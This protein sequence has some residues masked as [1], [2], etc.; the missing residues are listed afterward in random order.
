MEEDI[1][2]ESIID[3]Y[4][5]DSRVGQIIEKLKEPGLKHLNIEG[6]IGSAKSFVLSSVY[7]N[8]YCP[9]ICIFSDK[10]AAAY[11]F[12]DLERIIKSKRANI[13]GEI[14]FFPTSYKNNLSAGLQ[15]NAN[16]LAR[17]KVVEAL[18]A[19]KEQ[20]LIVTY[21]AAL[22]EK[23][24]TKQFL[25]KNTLF[26]EQGNQVSFDFILN[27][28][29]E[30]NFERVDFVVE[31]G[32]FTI[33]GG[34]FDVFSYSDDYPYRIELSG[35]TVASLRTFNPVNQL[36]VKKLNKISIIPNIDDRE[37]REQRK[38]FFDLIGEKTLLWAD[39][40]SQIVDMI[41][42]EIQ[43]ALPDSTD[44]INKEEFLRFVINHKTIELSSVPFF[45][46]NNTG[47][48]FPTGETS[49]DS[50]E[51]ST[52]RLNSNYIFNTIPQPHFSKNFDLFIQDLFE[53]T[54]NDYLNI[55]LSD[56]P[57]QTE[58][59]NTILS[60][61][62]ESRYK[63]KNLSFYNLNIA[64]YQGFIDSDLKLACYTDHQIFDR[65]HRYSLRENFEG[66]EAL[67]IKELTGL[68][69]GDY[70]T[71]I[72]YGIGV[73]DGLEKIEIN[74]KEQEAI[75][76]LY[77]DGDILYISIY[78]LHTISKYVG[79]EGSAPALHRLG[80]N[81]WANLK[82]KTKKKVK[83]IAKDLI[84]LYAMRKATVAFA[85]SPDTYL[86][87]ELEASFIYEDTPDQVKATVDVKKD[88]EAD[89]PMDR[90][91]CGDVG[92]GKTEIAVRAAFKAVAD[93]KQV[94]MLVPTTILALQHYYTF[95]DRLKD[96]PCRVEYVN[97][98]KSSKEIKKI[99]KDLE[100]GKV[101]IIIGTH[102]LLSKDIKFKDLGLLIIDEEQKFGVAAKEKI[103][104][105]KVNVD[106]LILTATPIPRTLQFSLMGAR[107]MSVISTPPPNRYPVNT[108]VHPFNEVIIKEAIELEISRGGQVFFVH[109]RI[110]NIIKIE[111]L[112]HRLLPGA[113][114]AVAHGR[115]TG[116]KLEKI[117]LDFIQGDYDVLLSTAI[118]ESGLDIA[119]VNTIIINDAH[120]FGLSDLHQLRGRV[121]RTNKKA[122]CYLLSPPFSLLSNDAKKRLNA[123]EEFSDLSSGFNIALRDLDIRG[124]GNILGGEQSGFIMEIGFETYQKILDEA[125]AEL[126][127][128]DLKDLFKDEPV[129]EI[130]RDCQVDTDLN[131][132]IP[133]NYVNNNA[134]RFTLYK[135]LNSLK[136]EEELQ[137]FILRLTDRFGALPPETFELT[138]I[139]RLRWRAKELGFEKIMLKNK[140]L[141]GYF[142]SNQ[143]SPFYKSDLFISILNYVKNNHHNC[144]LKEI[145][146]K[147]SLSFDKIENISQAINKLKEIQNK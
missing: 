80:S 42:K 141:T 31:P 77:K 35:D 139:I 14:L 54:K 11:F 126:K 13:E 101:D 10:E 73:F 118:I 74:G 92:F 86:Q 68:K 27:K 38:A 37:I 39:D 28:L 71:H 21:P 9:H 52:L 53:N 115:L 119:N 81:A 1:N 58:R 111:E 34:I 105:F 75:R 113:K 85:Y 69:Q 93:S 128:S 145:N 109:N 129:K 4:S 65:Y 89:F 127:E 20:L 147:L 23:V 96:L 62:K 46:G 124:A 43:G 95:S 84:K 132:L 26:I 90:L 2:I 66:R 120:H 130:V 98:F 49:A 142:I 87:A 5:A 63:D 107:D 15:D 51:A 36:S 60:D 123:I 45:S 32:Q 55:I 133:D 29:V 125:I 40:F 3:S 110:H 78:S 117:M 16:I 50:G 106:T 114:V 138:N 19:E 22:T 131:I 64:L 18:F 135:E 83:D 8:T 146:N 44:F 82:N 102:R 56:N 17:A 122:Y 88:M 59:L 94:A 143:D 7:I 134:E 6:L 121:G 104:Q 47:A 136:N 30:L 33:R 112:I 116:D 91:I 79:K 144:S 137:A 57:K 72:D 24:I 97:R 41:E 99:L 67:S 76:L 61:I 70:I 25:S 108:Q 100:E 48:E 12:N 103:K 140:I